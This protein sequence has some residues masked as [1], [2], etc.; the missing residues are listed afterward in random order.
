VPAISS[1]APVSYSFDLSIVAP[2]HTLV[3][4]LE[5]KL[6]QLGAD[7]V[8]ALQFLLM[9]PLLADKKRFPSA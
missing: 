4:S 6:Q 2:A 7:G 1:A 9:F 5:N 3:A 8:V